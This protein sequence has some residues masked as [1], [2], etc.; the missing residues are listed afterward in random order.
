MNK[1]SNNKAEIKNKYP[2][3]LI[4]QIA[5]IIAIYRYIHM[6]KGQSLN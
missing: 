3:L 1:D 4:T 2:Y 6:G 5:K